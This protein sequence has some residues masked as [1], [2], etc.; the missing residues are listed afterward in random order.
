[1][2][3]RPA[4]TS[5]LE[6]LTEP[7]PTVSH[8]PPKNKSNTPGRGW[9]FPMQLKVWEDFSS[10]KIL[11]SAFGGDLL[12]EARRGNRVLPQYPII[13]PKAD[14]V[15]RNERNTETLIN[16]W[17]REIVSAALDPIEREFHPVIWCQGDPP[18]TKEYSQPPP[19]PKNQRAQ[20]PRK[21][22]TQARRPKPQSLYRLSSDSGSI[23]W[24]SPLPDIDSTTVSR[25]QEMFPKEYKPASKW[26]SD[27]MVERELINESGEWETGREGSNLAMPIRQAYSYCIQ[28]MCRY[29]CILTCHEA[30]LFRIK[31]RDKE[32]T[33]ASQ[34]PKLLRDRLIE[35]G[36]MEYISIPWGNH[37]QG[38]VETHETWTINLALWFLHV[39]AGNSYEAGWEY[40][41]LKDE[42]LAVPIAVER[43]HDPTS[44]VTLEDE[45]EGDGREDEDDESESIDS[46]DSDRA[47]P[48]DVSQLPKRK[49]AE[50]EEEGYHLSFS[51]RQTLEV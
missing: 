18:A 41:S 39:L 16:K 7:N 22:S 40:G 15:I 4:A 45:G 49:R 30:F 35:N 20:P 46:D 24:N 29:G 36:L 51:K 33:N 6:L 5:I 38:D 3:N 28:H 31:P 2:A 32:P 43:Q 37:R 1:M 13:R 12:R 42:R 8:P 21:S 14:C 47:A 34:D 26:R 48:F 9:H 25:C 17:N 10:F 19:R 27:W 11:E 23:P 44:A 50:D